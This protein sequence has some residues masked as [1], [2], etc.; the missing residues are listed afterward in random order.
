MKKET[1]LKYSLIALLILL[2]VPC[3]VQASIQTPSLQ[4]IEEQSQRDINYV[5]EYA[6]EI[7]EKD[8]QTLQ[9]LYQNNPEEF[10][11]MYPTLNGEILF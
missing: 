4:K 9:N 5:N 10:A 7:A 8:R 2:N 1:G 11:K 3:T 6:D